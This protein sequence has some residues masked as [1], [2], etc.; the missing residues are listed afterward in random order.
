MLDIEPPHAT[1][2]IAVNG[3]YPPE[4][5][6][7]DATGWADRAGSI[8]YVASQVRTCQQVELAREN[9]ARLR[10]H[11]VRSRC[12]SRSPTRRCG[13]SGFYR[14]FLATRTGRSSCAPVAPTHDGRSAPVT[15]VHEH[16]RLGRISGIP[17]GLNASVAVIVALITW[18]LAA[19]LL[20]DLVPD[21]SA[22]AYWI[23]AALAA[24]VFFAS[25]VTHELAHTVVARRDGIGVKGITLW[26]LGG[27]SLLES[28]P[29]TAAAEL[30]MAVAGPATSMALG[31]A[32]GVLAVAAAALSLSD[33]AI[34]SL[35][36]LAT[37]NLFLGLFNLL[38][39]FPLDGGR[40]LR[41]IFWSRTGDATRATEAAVRAGRWA[42]YG[43]IGLGVLMAVSIS[44]VS[45]FWLMF[46]GWYIEGAGRREVSA[47]TEQRILAGLRARELM[48][49][50]VVTVPADAS[51]EQLLHDYVL[52]RHHSAFPVIDTTGLLV[53][54]VS[55][56]E[57]R[58]VTPDARPSTPV[59]AIARPVSQVPVVSP[60]APTTEVLTQLAS[61]GSRRAL[62]VD[63]SRLVGIIAEADIARAI[64]VGRL[65]PAPSR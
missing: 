29:Q 19:S 35:S 30:R 50:P 54:L 41:A 57:V 34:A 52:G 27:V 1:P 42:A 65:H 31:L 63:G 25:L 6:G 62:V 15:P 51:V 14:Q 43:L 28:E 21:R 3:F 49:A 26:M 58:P 56:D 38:P 40:V 61:T 23:T 7:E 45:G 48:S 2:S 10:R 12:C 11:C 37:I 33:L 44:V 24:T 5:A 64:E 22:V 55:L 8:L 13:A 53:G 16:L 32:F 9:L 60:D 4:F 39:A 18:V 59:G 17:I 36:W 20:P 47:A 46:L